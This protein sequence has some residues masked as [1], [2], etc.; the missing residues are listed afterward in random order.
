MKTIIGGILA[1]IKITILIKVVYLLYLTH[2]DPTNNSIDKLTWWIY[3]LVFEI[4]LYISFKDFGDET[5]DE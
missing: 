5:F 2:S 1:V 4:W 3:F